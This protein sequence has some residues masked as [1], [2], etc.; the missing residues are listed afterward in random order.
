MRNLLVDM[1]RTRVLG[2]QVF[3]IL[4][5]SVLTL[6]ASLFFT[7]LSGCGGSSG[8]TSNQGGTGSVVGIESLSEIPLDVLDPAQYDISLKSGSNNLSAK[9]LP[10]ELGGFSR[11]GCE[12][13]QTRNRIVR[14]AKFPK[15]ILCYMTKMSD[16]LG[17]ELGDGDYNYYNLGEVPGGPDKMDGSMEMKIAIKKVN[18]T[19]TMLMCESDAKVMEFVITA[20]SDNGIYQGHII[21]TWT[22]ESEQG[23]ISEARS[24]EF[25]TD[26]NSSNFTNADF[27]QTFVSDQWG[28]GSE[29]L[30][31]TPS[32]AT[33]QGYHHDS[34]Q[35]NNF[36]GSA[37]AQF[38]ASQGTTKYSATGTYPATQ[39]AEAA[40]I[41]QGWYQYLID[42]EWGLGL[43]DNDYVCCDK[44][45]CFQVEGESSCEF[46]DSGTE[47]FA[48]AGIL[49]NLTF[50]VIGSSDYVD[51]VN[52]VTLQNPNS[53]PS[54]EFSS[55]EF[56]DCGTNAEWISISGTGLD[57]NVDDCM[58]IEEELTEFQDHDGCHQLEEQARQI[59]QNE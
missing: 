46:T 38:D 30:I 10:G 24:L 31:A 34:F 54:I 28:Y 53:V 56:T 21:D 35:G 12:A 52:A 40:N 50:T 43:T 29:S 17:I 27:S 45:G 4:G 15:M 59:E 25:N 23:A 6:V 32:S 44:D 36:S 48:I 37:Y 2:I 39:V 57:V 20:D 47:S 58:A 55:T 1:F 41:D 33:V 3:K 14:E 18:N 9:V 8:V 42:S 16:E 7:L 5:L 26:G 13:N 19:I 22:F 11:A 51:T 49:P